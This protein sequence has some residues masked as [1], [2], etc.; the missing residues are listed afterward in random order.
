[1]TL[2]HH[3]TEPTVVRYALARLE[4]LLPDG[5]LLRKRAAYVVPNG[6]VDSTPFMR[7][8]RATRGYTETAASSI[9]ARL[10]T[11]YPEKIATSALVDWIIT[12]LSLG[13]EAKELNNPSSSASANAAVCALMIMV[14]NE[15]GRECFIAAG[16]LKLLSEILRHVGDRSQLSYEVCFC[17]WTLTFCDSAIVAFGTTGALLA[18]IDKLH[19]SRR[20]KITRVCLCALKNLLGKN[21]G[22]FN[23]VMIESGMLKSLGKMKEQPWT[24]IDIVTDVSSIRDVLLREFK[25]LTTMDRY[26]KELETGTLSWGLLHTE[27]FW[28]EN[29]MAFENTE[30]SNIK[31]LISLLEGKSSRETIAVVL[32]DLGEFVRF[33]PNGKMILKRLGAKAF[34]M[35]LMT[36]DHAEVR[37]Q[38]LLC[39]SKMMVNKWEFVK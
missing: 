20:D 23:E 25:E 28:Q 37:K 36:D 34:V 35:Q 27:K 24:D 12:C 7:L 33:Y 39:M 9:L 32:F 38:A 21:N 2:L 8:I 4:E 26:E 6:Q 22:V 31:A 14:R 11:V 10:L 30:F 19:S 1:M 29:Y 17:L 5:I 18:I 3:V 16:G 15:A 13:P